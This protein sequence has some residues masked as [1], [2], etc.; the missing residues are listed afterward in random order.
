MRRLSGIAIVSMLSLVTACSSDSSQVEPVEIDGVWVFQQS[1][2]GGDDA[3]HNGEVAIR[4]GCLYVGDAIVVWHP[5]QMGEVEDLIA[6]AAAGEGQQISIP[7]GGA[8]PEE[9]GSTLPEEITSRCS[10][11]TVWY[12]RPGP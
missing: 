7:G 5:G 9:T 4:D 8:T 6:D 11:D 10:T 12:T 2:S 1:S 3:L